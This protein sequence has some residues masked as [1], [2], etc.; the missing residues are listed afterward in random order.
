MSH[1][2][3]TGKWRLLI[4]K[5]KSIID[6]VKDTINEKIIRVKQ[7][8]SLREANA[9]RQAGILMSVEIFNKA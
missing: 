6:N 4:L 1:I 9:S 2:T 8:F 3:S 5:V 7:G